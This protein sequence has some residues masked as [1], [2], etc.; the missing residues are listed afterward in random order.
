MTARDL[1][2]T[3]DDATLREVVRLACRAPSVHNTQPWRWRID[4]A[5][6][7][8]HVDRSRQLT[9][10]DPDGRDLLIS[11]GAALHHAAVAA[12]GLGVP[13]HVVRF[14][15]ASDPDHLATLTLAPGSRTPRALA[16]LHALEQ[17]RTDRRRFTSWPIP[18]ERLAKL[19]ASVE[20]HDVHVLPLTDV[21][22]RFR[23]ELLISR[24]MTLQ[25]GDEALGEEQ[26]RWIDHS[27]SDG[28]PSDRVPDVD[29]YPSHRRS[30]FS[31]PPSQ[32]SRHQLVESTD[33]L[34]AICTE[35]DDR[36]GWL[37]AGEALSGLWLHATTDGLSVVPL[38]Q[39]IEVAETRVAL[40]HEVFGALVAPQILLRIGWQEIARSELEPTPRRP[41][42]DVLLP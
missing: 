30:R 40:R 42:E 25:D 16:E 1:N 5:R 38:S 22:V 23:V 41:V 4:G 8:L 7:E 12:A 33:G 24:A 9:V 27:R 28:V 32:D 19:A 21:S 39:V 35:K 31:P 34:L 18:D 17:R 37:E 14:P 10:A 13:A 26:R 11:C 29:V 6:L 3:V 15:D 2:G 20:H 36:T